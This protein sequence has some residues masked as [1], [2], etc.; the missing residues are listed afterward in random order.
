MKKM[1]TVLGLKLDEPIK[2]ELPPQITQWILER[3]E[4]RKNK[5]WQKADEIRVK[6]EASGKWMVKDGA[7][8]TEV[9]PK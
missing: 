5:D 6:I 3:N 8:G 9:Q 2:F 1:D 4:A 7:G